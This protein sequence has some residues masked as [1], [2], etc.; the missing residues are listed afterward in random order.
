MLRQ[1][2]FVFEIQMK[3]LQTAHYGFLN[4]I[5]SNDCKTKKKKKIE[6]FFGSGKIQN[7]AM[8]LKRFINSSVLWWFPLLF[9]FPYPRKKK[10]GLCFGS[11]QGS[12]FYNINWNAVEQF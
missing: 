3:F 5:W 4:C 12:I 10:D 6:I 8:N 9:Y 1:L 7:I 2:S 11:V